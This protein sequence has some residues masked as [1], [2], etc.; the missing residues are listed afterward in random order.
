[1]NLLPTAILAA[2]PLAAAAFSPRVLL[3]VDPA[4]VFVTESAEVTV[5]ILSERRFQVAPR[6]GADFI[7]QGSRLEMTCERTT[8]GG[9]NAWLYAVKVP[10]RTER[11]GRMSLGPVSVS[12]PE[13]FGFFGMLTRGQELRSGTV[14]LGVLAP[15]EA[16]RPGSYC[17]ALS[18]GFSA[19]ASVDSNVCTAGDP[20]LLTLELSGATDVSM[21]YPPRTLAEAFRDTPFRIDLASRRT[22]SDGDRKRFSWRLRALRAGT[23]EIPPLEAAFFDIP[24]RSYRTV[25]TPPIPVQVNAG[26]QA[27]LAASD[28]GEDDGFPMPDGL[29]LSFAMEDFTLR[30]AVSLACRAEDEAGFAA[31]AERYAA[32]VDAPGRGGESM[33]VHLSNLGSLLVMAGKPREALAAYGRAERVSGATP[34][35]E[36][37]MRA[38]LARLRNDPAAELPLPRIL[39]PF[40]FRLS[41]AG[42]ILSACGAL[43][44]LAGLFWLSVRAGR[45]LSAIAVAIAIAQGAS[46][47][48][49]G[50]N[51]PFAGLFDDMFQKRRMDDGAC[52][53]AAKASFAASECMVGEP[54]DLVVELRPGQVRVDPGSVRIGVEIAGER[55][56]GKGARDPKSGAFVIPVTFLSAATNSAEVSVS[57]TYSGTYC[58]TNGN[59]ISSGRVVNQQF[60]LSART[61]GVAVRPLPAD[62]RPDDFSGA[63]GASFRLSQSASPSRVRPG[64][65]V[66]VEYRLDFDGYCPS[67][68][69]L[70][71]GGGDGSAF[72]AYGAREASR[73]P[74]SVV[75]RQMLVP[76][77]SSATNTPSASFG[78]F[79]LKSGR[80][81]R[82]A[83]PPAALSYVSSEAAPTESARVA[84]DSAPA[85]GGAAPAAAAVLR[86]A[87]S[88]RSPVVAELPPGTE[89]RETERRGGWRRI[90][91]ARGAGWTR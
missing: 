10:V 76:L 72:R 5:G 61:P 38:A 9:T 24:S 47:F 17:G 90:Q 82:V 11:P 56:V 4:E 35:T 1:M 21:V 22:D 59:M 23:A 60:S 65:L 57:G 7:P 2:L 64:D 85:A 6:I 91:S 89:A 36:R 87:P 79:N 74:G 50:G 54:V 27:A 16:G 13:R 30:H 37:G 12:L 66:T 71:V 48:P 46:A 40:W 73:S 28:D 25:R 39:F 33:A 29:E 34:A 18:K 41:L 32:F 69:V 80:Y 53:I 43:L 67:N 88:D 20:L 77:T 51:S 81:E 31:A 75:W 84:V 58:V 63:V 8:L 45:R 15:P 49:F 62:G 70:R 83:A 14:S 3:S 26:A 52:P 86:F 68:A 78:Y 42:R 44:A 55:V 19:A